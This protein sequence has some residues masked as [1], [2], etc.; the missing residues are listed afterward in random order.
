MTITPA[1]M[2]WFT[3]LD[4]LNVAFAVATFLG[5]FAVII[6]AIGFF[7]TSNS[8]YDNEEKNHNTIKSVLKWLVPTWLICLLGLLFTPTTKEIAMIY[9]VP[10]IAES[11]I[12]KQDIPELYDLGVNALK[13]W[14]K[15][16]KGGDNEQ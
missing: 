1:T 5:I 13:D 15:Q 6:T 2:Y 12:I 7:A 9:V 10:H 16:T 8:E 3:R 4:G 14:L 11:Q